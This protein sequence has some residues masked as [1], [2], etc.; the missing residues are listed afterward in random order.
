MQFGMSLLFSELI[1]TQQLRGNII[2]SCIF[3]SCYFVRHFP[4]LA[5]S[6]APNLPQ[7]LMHTLLNM[8][9]VPN[10]Q[11]WLMSC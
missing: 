7:V 4:G 5:F 3:Q 6:V 11:V 9:D 8:I 1:H 10:L 2:S